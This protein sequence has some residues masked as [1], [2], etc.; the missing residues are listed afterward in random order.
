MTTKKNMNNPLPYL[1][2]RF[3]FQVVFAG[4]FLLAMHYFLPNM[5]GYGLYLPY[6]VIGWM[7]IATLIG[8][9]FWQISRTGFIELSKTQVLFSIGFLF[10]LLPLAYSINEISYRTTSR[11]MFLLGG[12]GFYT[13]LVQFRFNQS[14]RFTLLY[15]ILGAIGVQSILGVIQY[16]GLGPGDHFLLV[17][18]TLPYGSFQQKNVMTIFMVTGM[19]IGLF[20]IGKDH[21]LASSRLKRWLVLLPPLTGSI[22]I[23]AIKSK[24]GYLGLLV[25][26][27]LLLPTI[28]VKEKLYQRWFMLLV[29]GL[30]IGYVSPRAYQFFQSGAQPEGQTETQQEGGLYTRSLGSQIATVNTRIDMWEI[31]FDIWK[32]NPLTGIGYGKWPRIFR[33]YHAFRRANATGSDYFMGEYLDHPHN[34]TLLWL[35]EGGIAPF[36]G[37]LIFAGGYLI[38]VFRLKWKNVLSCLALVM[39]IFLHTQFELPFDI[40]LAHWIVF[41]TL[42]HF[43]D[44]QQNIRYRYNLHKTMII[45]ALM[46]PLM[47]YY[48]MGT[49]LRINSTISRFEH[50]GMKNYDLLLQVKDSGALHLKYDNYVLKTMLDLGMDTKNEEALQLFLEKAEEFVQRSPILHVYNGMMKALL[51]LGREKEAKAM[52]ARARYLYPD[53]NEAWLQPGNQK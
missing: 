5:G 33:E 46:I 51:V 13:A 2:P 53:T 41:L 43:P 12:L 16:Y 34:E 47:V 50:T 48:Y 23:M 28:N 45:P 26:F 7:F 3:L 38:M 14:E 37:L 31:T 25:M 15:I 32:D 29:T 27:P 6:N 1:K 49:T 39:P 18:K 22:I 44:D 17:K 9:G 42:C 19:G 24:A 30:I 21:V 10:C 35:S 20:L 36:L 8:L 40:S 4:Y 11:V 52:V